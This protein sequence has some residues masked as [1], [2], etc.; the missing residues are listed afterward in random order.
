V[1]FNFEHD[2]STRRLWVQNV[3]LMLNIDSIYKI[4]N[5]LFKKKYFIQ[6][7]KEKE[8]NISD[9]ILEAKDEFSVFLD[10][11][12]SANEIIDFSS[13]FNL[14]I[15]SELLF[16]N[17][18]ETR[19]KRL[20]ILITTAKNFYI[21]NKKQEALE[22]VWDAY[23]RLKTYLDEDKRKGSEQLIILMADEIKK[24]IFDDEFSILTKIGNEYM[25]RHSET[26][27][28][29]LDKDNNKDYLF[30]RMLSLLNLSI[31][32]LKLRNL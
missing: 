19:D 26:D 3:L 13:A 15:N 8:L 27:K 17:I 23:E 1:G 20:N 18:I 9:F 11:C 31:E 4:I 28:I 6:F 21:D 32:K 14:N 16:D 10:N 12:F 22:K 30:F 24:A 5:E 2:G 7:C 29:P 25:I